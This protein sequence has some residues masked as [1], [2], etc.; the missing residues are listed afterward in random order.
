VPEGWGVKPFSEIID[1]NPKRKLLKGSLAKK[2]GMSYLNSWQSWIESWQ[3]EEYKSGPRFQTGDILFARITPSLEHGKTAMVSF[4][5][6]GEIAFGST[7]F[8]VF[9]PKIIQS[10]LYIFC[11][12]RSENVREIA[13][14]AMTGSSGRQRVP[15]ECFDHLLV[16]APPYY[17][18]KDFD[19]ILRPMFEVISTNAK[20]NQSLI[21]IRDILLLKLMSG[22][23]RVKCWKRE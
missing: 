21:Q 12:A 2:V 16:S 10:S 13:I 5:G 11:L 20:E 18:I 19:N 15:N 22:E 1:I 17:I 4:L 3:I 14:G 23:I 9:A 8:I 6:D 7:E